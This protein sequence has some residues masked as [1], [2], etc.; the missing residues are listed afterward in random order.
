MFGRIGRRDEWFTLRL[1]KTLFQRSEQIF[2]LTRNRLFDC[3][4]EETIAHLVE[5]SVRV[6]MFNRLIDS[7]DGLGDTFRAALKGLLERDELI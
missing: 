6:E 2:L 1:A 3:P 7:G 4:V 5:V